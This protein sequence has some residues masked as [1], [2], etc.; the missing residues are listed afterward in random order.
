MEEIAPKGLLCL[1]AKKDAI[2]LIL[3]SPQILSGQKLKF[4]I[5]GYMDEII[6][7]PARTGL[8]SLVIYIGTN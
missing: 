3:S 2:A 4:P 5:I 7:K 6:G 8:L 1:Y